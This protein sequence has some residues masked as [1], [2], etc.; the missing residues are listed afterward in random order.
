MV[1][2]GNPD[3]MW[4]I[5][6]EVR[7]CR[8]LLEEHVAIRLHGRVADQ[9]QTETDRGITTEQDAE[10]PFNSEQHNKEGYDPL[11]TYVRGSTCYGCTVIFSSE[12][13]KIESK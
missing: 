2:I 8:L 4:R 9:Q 7:R 11:S 12:K 10:L 13:N 1:E 3:D 5:G 6:A